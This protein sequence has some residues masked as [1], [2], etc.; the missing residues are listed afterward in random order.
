M[1]VI[2]IG[3]MLNA[4]DLTEGIFLEETSQKVNYCVTT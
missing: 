3:L 2:I 4:P 1:N